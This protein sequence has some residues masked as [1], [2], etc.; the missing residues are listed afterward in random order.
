M[1]FLYTIG[2]LLGAAPLRIT[3]F[4]ES[5]QVVEGERLTLV[6]TI[7]SGDTP[8]ELRWTVIPH[9]WKASSSLLSSARGAKAGASGDDYGRYSGSRSELKLIGS[10]REIVGNEKNSGSFSVLNTDPYNSLLKIDK[11]TESHT[12]QYYCDASSTAGRVFRSHNLTVFGTRSILF[13]CS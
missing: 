7:S 3:L 11:V 10:V 2:L 1:I 9:S 12:G 8:V 6:C 13:T 4:P 5:S